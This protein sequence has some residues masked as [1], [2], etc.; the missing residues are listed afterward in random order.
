MATRII[1]LGKTEHFRAGDS[2]FPAHSK[3]PLTEPDP[4]KASER[5]AGWED[6]G[7]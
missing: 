4:K 1:S 3:R 5:Q 2:C 6:E 7:P